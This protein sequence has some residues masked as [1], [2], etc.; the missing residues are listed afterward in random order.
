MFGI[1]EKWFEYFESKNLRLPLD[2]DVNLF[3]SLVVMIFQYDHAYAT[4]QCLNFWY[5]Y[6]NLFSKE[7][8]SK[9][10]TIILQKFFFKLFLHW[11]KSIR[12]IFFYFLSYRIVFGFELSPTDDYFPVLLNVE[13]L[14]LKVSRIAYTYSLSQKKWNSMDKIHR[15]LSGGY[16]RFISKVSQE[17][18]QDIRYMEAVDQNSVQPLTIKT[19]DLVKLQNEKGSKPSESTSQVVGPIQSSVNSQFNL[20]RMRK[21][22]DA[23]ELWI[24]RSL[25]EKYSEKFRTLKKTDSGKKRMSQFQK[26]F[27]DFFE[28]A[29]L[30]G[31]NIDDE[32]SQHLD[33]ALYPYCEKAMKE[34]NHIFQSFYH[35]FK[36][37]RQDLDVVFVDFAIPFDKGDIAFDMDEDW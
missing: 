33:I 6:F 2:F 18:K 29:K 17:I 9:L 14:I 13:S 32:A 11:N 24:K 12:E 35:G 31:L 16:S 37:E 8:N 23:P 28:V 25:I 10:L 22:R 34:F 5:I 19:H 21:N 15:I 30:T 27:L 7:F 20:S 36:I 1:L 4:G 3:L 26:E